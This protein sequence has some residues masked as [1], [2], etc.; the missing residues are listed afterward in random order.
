MVRRHVRARVQARPHGSRARA[1][2]QTATARAWRGRQEG[3]ALVGGSIGTKGK[4]MEPSATSRWRRAGRLWRAVEGMVEGGVDMFLVEDM[5]PR[6]TG[7]LALNRP[8]ALGP[9]GVVSL[10]LNE[11]GITSRRQAG[12]S[13][14]HAGGVGRPSSALNRKQPWAAADGRRSRRMDRREERELADMPNARAGHGRGR[15]GSVP[16]EY[17][18][19]YARRFLPPALVRGRCAAP[20]PSTSATSCAPWLGHGARWW[21]HRG[22]KGPGGPAR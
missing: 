16:P 10:N 4:P 18:A 12:R 15:Y 1:E 3:R 21:C 8:R 5:P 19:S 11:E 13:R 2:D 14:A 7:G 9:P 20:R 17:M 22:P 6:W